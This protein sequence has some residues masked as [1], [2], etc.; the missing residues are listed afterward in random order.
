MSERGL[1]IEFRAGDVTLPVRCKFTERLIVPCCTLVAVAH[2]G[3]KNPSWSRV[4]R[5]ERLGSA[6][7]AI[8]G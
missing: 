3:D 4:S 2:L 7:G 1:G 8:V 5:R 6:A